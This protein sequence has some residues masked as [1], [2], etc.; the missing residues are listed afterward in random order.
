MKPE[1]YDARLPERWRGKRRGLVAYRLAAR[2]EDGLRS[3]FVGGFVV[4]GLTIV[5]HVLF[6]YFTRALRS[7]KKISQVENSHSFGLLNRDIV[8]P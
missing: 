2:R 6:S 7:A 8:F 4:N 5:F 3:A 1:L